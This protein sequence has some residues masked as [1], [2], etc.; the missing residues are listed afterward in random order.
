MTGKSFYCLFGGSVPSNFYNPRD[1]SYGGGIIIGM[2]A[3]GVYAESNES[4]E[5]TAPVDPLDENTR[6]RFTFDSSYGMPNAGSSS[7]TMPT[8][9][10]AKVTGVLPSDYS[11]KSWNVYVDMETALK[12]KKESD[13]YYGN[14]PA[15]SVTY[16]QIYVKADSLKNT[17]AISEQIQQMGYQTYNSA[18]WIQSYQKQSQSLQLILGGIGAVSLLVAAIGITNTMIMS[19][20]ERTREI[21]IMK[22]L[23]CVLGDIKTLFLY[24]AA[25]IGLTGGLA[26]IAFSYLV[27][28]LL[29]TVSSDGGILGGMSSGSKLSVI[30]PWLALSAVLFAVLV[31]LVSGYL[32]ARRAMKLSSLEAMRS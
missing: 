13:K 15:T 7:G 3:D 28:A 17:M 29:N 9:Y 8:L 24:E 22:V 14:K 27:S 4:T 31:G 19:I 5:P 30:P 2:A 25:I 23:G 10:T 32:P 12:L 18:E 11:E 21:G 20:Y 16:D 1:N 26:G 6:I